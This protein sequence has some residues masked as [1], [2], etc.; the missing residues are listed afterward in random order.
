MKTIETSAGNT[1]PIDFAYAPTLD[2]SCM[3]RLNDESRPLWEVA[4]EFDELA[5]IEKHDPGAGV[6]RYEGYTR[7]TLVQRLDN[8]I[9][10]I[11]LSKA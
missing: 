3:L 2:G 9:V 1:Y 6:E 8:S 10:L 5:W 11:K 4:E 7:L